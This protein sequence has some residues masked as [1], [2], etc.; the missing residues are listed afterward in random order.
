[1]WSPFVM[2]KNNFWLC[3]HQSWCNISWG[4]ITLMN[5]FQFRL[6]NHVKYLLFITCQIPKHW[7]K[8]LPKL[9]N[10]TISFLSNVKRSVGNYYHSRKKLC[11]PHHPHQWHV[12]QRMIPYKSIRCNSNHSHNKKNNNVQTNYVCIMENH[13]TL[14]AIVQRSKCNTHP[15]PLLSTPFILKILETWMFSLN[16]DHETKLQCIMWMKWSQFIFRP[17][18][19]FIIFNYNQM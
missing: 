13:V 9:F 1:M 3:N 7:I 14:L 2:G 18:I 16:K 10:V 4:E 12:H 17:N 19:L 15:R 5:Q 8:P 6:C 11:P